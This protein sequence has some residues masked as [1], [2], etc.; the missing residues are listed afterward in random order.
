M[1]VADTIYTFTDKVHRDADGYKICHESV[2]YVKQQG[3]E[4]MLGRYMF[5][6]ELQFF[7]WDERKWGAMIDYIK[8]DKTHKRIKIQPF[9]FLVEDIGDGTVNGHSFIKYKKFYIDP[10]FDS[11]RLSFNDIQKTGKWFENTFRVVGI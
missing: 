4:L 1:K 3:K 11:A 2:Y 10:Y 7:L 8:Q 9:Q 5:Y 6:K